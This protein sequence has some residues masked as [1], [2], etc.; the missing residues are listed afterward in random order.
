[1]FG[2]LAGAFLGLALV[3]ATVAV[4]APRRTRA[5]RRREA[6]AQRELAAHRQFHHRLHRLALASAQVEHFAQVVLDELANHTQK[7]HEI[8]EA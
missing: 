3:A 5:A 8:E 4:L 6:A 2:L 7:T 1:M